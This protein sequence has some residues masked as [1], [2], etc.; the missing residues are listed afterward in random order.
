MIVDGDIFYVICFVCCLN[1]ME[2]LILLKM[3][4]EFVV[5]EYLIELG[6]KEKFIGVVNIYFK[7]V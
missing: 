3:V 7:V 2:F 5:K 1:K 4:V 6:L